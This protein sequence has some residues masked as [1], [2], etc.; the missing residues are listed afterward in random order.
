MHRSW[1]QLKVTHPQRRQHQGCLS[2]G[3]PLLL[4]LLREGWATSREETMNVVPTTA[5]YRWLRRT[6]GM[7]SSDDLSWVMLLAPF[8]GRPEP[9]APLDDQPG[10]EARDV[11]GH[12]TPDRG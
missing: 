11:A 10:N 6:W 1:E 4:P 8:D 2:T 5:G 7:W 3:L 12:R 9:L